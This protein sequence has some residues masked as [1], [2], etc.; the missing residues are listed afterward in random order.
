MISLSWTVSSCIKNQRQMASSHPRT[1]R[2]FW[3]CGLKKTGNHSLHSPVFAFFFLNLI[4]SLWVI[5]FL[6]EY[7]RSK[8]AQRKS[9]RERVREWE[10]GKEIE[11]ED[12][13]W[14][15]GFESI[16]WKEWDWPSRLCQS[17]DRPSAFFHCFHLP[18]FSFFLFLCFHLMNF[19]AGFLPWLP[20]H[21][22][23]IHSEKE[24][25]DAISLGRWKHPRLHHISG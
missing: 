13:T 15:L 18:V 10:L 22:T 6:L 20:L 1:F 2:T 12:R 23:G 24:A 14:F 3:F 9:E 5:F 7:K 19:N 25:F 11:T 8:I 16:T 4:T 17:S 21:L